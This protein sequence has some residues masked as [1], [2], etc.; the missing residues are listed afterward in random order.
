MRNGSRGSTSRY[1][2]SRSATF[3]AFA[4]PVMRFRPNPPMLLGGSDGACVRAL[5]GGC[6]LRPAAAT[7][8]GLARHLAGAGVAKIRLLRATPRVGEIDPH[9]GALCLLDLLAAIVADKSRYACHPIPPS[10][11]DFDC[12]DLTG[13]I[14]ELG[15][16]LP[17]LNSP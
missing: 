5:G 10:K 17:L 6:G 7:G 1:R 12:A 15:G 16:S 9:D 14:R 2:R 8:Y 13:K 3:P 11:T 4:G